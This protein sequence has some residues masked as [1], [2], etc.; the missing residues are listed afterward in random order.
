MNLRKLNLESRIKINPIFEDRNSLYASPTITNVISIPIKQIIGEEVKLRTFIANENDYNNDVKLSEKCFSFCSDL[1][2]NINPNE[3]EITTCTSSILSHITLLKQQQ[4]Q[5]STSNDQ[6]HAHNPN[7][8]TNTNTQEIN[9]DTDSDPINTEPI[10][11]P[12]PN[13]NTNTTAPIYPIATA[14]AT[15]TTTVSDTNHL[16]I[17]PLNSFHL[18]DRFTTVFSTDNLSSINIPIGRG[19]YGNIHVKW[20]GKRDI[21]MSIGRYCSIAP[22]VTVIFNNNDNGGCYNRISAYPFHRIINQMK[23]EGMDGMEGFHEGVMGSS[24]DF[25]SSSNNNDCERGNKN[26]TVTIG[27]DVW[28]GLGVTIMEGVTVGDGAVIGTKSVVRTEVL[29]YSVVIG[30]PAVHYKY[31]FPEQYIPLLLETKWWDWSLEDIIRNMDVILGDD[32]EAFI[33][34]SKEKDMNI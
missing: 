11:T 14:T 22:D 25:D 3:Y 8:S 19:T 4:Q 24:G 23:M 32:I 6:K 29:P 9:T 5:Y 16:P 7:N 26:S 33:S 2:S 12:L 15:A 1:Y 18:Y 28:I 21:S 30:N 27:N 20:S 34:R 10:I 17:Q 13:S 31:R